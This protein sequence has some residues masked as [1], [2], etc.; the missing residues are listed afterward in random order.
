L[1]KQKR[2]RFG[3]AQR[4]KNNFPQDV[5]TN[6]SVAFPSKGIS[7]ARSLSEVEAWKIEVKNKKPTTK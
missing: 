7:I 5:K 2:P 3:F 1:H 6:L 4:P